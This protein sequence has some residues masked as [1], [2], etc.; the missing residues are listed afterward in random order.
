MNSYGK[1]QNFTYSRMWF[2]SLKSLVLKIFLDPG[3]LASR[4]F[5]LSSSS[6]NYMKQG[7]GSPLVMCSVFLG[8]FSIQIGLTWPALAS[9]QCS[10]VVIYYDPE[11]LLLVFCIFLVAGYLGII[12]IPAKNKF[13]FFCQ[14]IHKNKIK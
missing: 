4:F 9:G 7:F 8:P 11:S 1:N 10:E 13:C 2:F 14:I 3:F 5:N 12:I 6:M